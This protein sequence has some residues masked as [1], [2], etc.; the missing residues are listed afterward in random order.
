MDCMDRMDHM[1]QMDRM[2]QM[3][4]MDRMNG[5]YRIDQIL[6]SIAIYNI[7][8]TSASS[9]LWSLLMVGGF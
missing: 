4:Q 2:D 1:D 9:S 6:V 7:S 8:L 5:M 3:D